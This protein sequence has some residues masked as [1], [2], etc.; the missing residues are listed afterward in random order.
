MTSRSLATPCSILRANAPAQGLAC[1][2]RFVRQTQALKL[3]AGA[4][5]GRSSA[6][7]C[8]QT[9]VLLIVNI[10]ASAIST[11]SSTDGHLHYQN[12]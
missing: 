10:D 6:S 5:I 9:C 1:S 4:R 12:R 2:V 8:G 7:F 11:L 3:S